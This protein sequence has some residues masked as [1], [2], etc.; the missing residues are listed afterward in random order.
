MKEIV[1]NLC[2]L[3]FW[4]AIQLLGLWSIIVSYL[5]IPDSY[6]M[7]L[8]INLDKIDPAQQLHLNMKVIKIIKSWSK[9]KY[10]IIKENHNNNCITWFSSGFL[11]DQYIKLLGYLVNRWTCWINC[12][13]VM[14]FTSLQNRW[15][16]Y[17]QQLMKTIKQQRQN[18]FRVLVRCRRILV[19]HR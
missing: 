11:L 13:M 10:W 2:Y 1:K 17:Q 3:R 5:Y 15:G 8:L 14:T 19:H 4:N 12:L 7:L 18:I 16:Q 9:Q 6:M